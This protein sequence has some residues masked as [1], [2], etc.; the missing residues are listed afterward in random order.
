MGFLSKPH[1]LPPGCLPAA[2]DFEEM[3]VDCL[4][5]L[6]VQTLLTLSFYFFWQ[7]WWGGAFIRVAGSAAWALGLQEFPLQPGEQLAVNI[8]N[9]LSCNLDFQM[10]NLAVFR[11]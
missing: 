9:L 4:F 1:G 3:L 6:K 7:G 11:T 8:P 5:G 2:A 10:T